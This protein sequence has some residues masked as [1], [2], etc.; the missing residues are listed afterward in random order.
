MSISKMSAKSD[1]EIIEVALRVRLLKKLC[2][3]YRINSDIIRKSYTEGIS[4]ETLSSAIWHQEILLEV[5]AFCED[6][7]SE[8]FRE[9]ID[10]VYELG[11]EEKFSSSSTDEE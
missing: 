7:D 10:I 2:E 3:W 9:A 11:F 4:E 6:G 5:I 1:E 8:E